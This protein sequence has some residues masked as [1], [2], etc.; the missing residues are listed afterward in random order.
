MGGGKWGLDDGGP[1]GNADI[2]WTTFG[3]GREES[4]GLQLDVAGMVCEACQ[5]AGVL[6][7][8]V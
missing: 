6:A 4:F 7:E 2:C 3:E 8:C 5:G 1:E